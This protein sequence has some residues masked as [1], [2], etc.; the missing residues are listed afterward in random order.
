[1]YSGPSTNNYYYNDNDNDN[2]NNQKSWQ[3]CTARRPTFGVIAEV[4]P[5]GVTQEVGWN[6]DTCIKT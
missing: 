5:S 3:N 4:N 6:H 1:M 2:N